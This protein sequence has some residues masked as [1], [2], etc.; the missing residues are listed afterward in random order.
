MAGVLAMDVS[1][2][3]DLLVDL[4]LAVQMSQRTTSSTSISSCSSSWGRRYG[5]LLV[6][7]SRSCSTISE[8]M[9][10]VRGSGPLEER[11]WW[12]VGQDVQGLTQARQKV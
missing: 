1:L 2:I 8:R 11:R 10:L 7:D 3:K 12:Q 4:L 6:P 9:E 5:F